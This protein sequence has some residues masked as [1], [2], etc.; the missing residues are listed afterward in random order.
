ML[1][2]IELGGTNI[3]CGV[4]LDGANF[5]ETTQIGTTDPKSAV[6]K[7]S[8]FLSRCETDHRKLQG[9]G[10]ASFGPVDIDVDSQTYGT[11]LETPKSGWSNYSLLKSLRSHFSSPV[12]VTTDVNAALPVKKC[13]GGIDSLVV[14]AEI[15]GDSGL[16][17]ALIIA[18]QAARN[19]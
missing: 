13:I 5:I 7:I 14:K 1:G 12:L 2:A 9:L 17:G 4:S 8:D 10:L 6:L 3:I 15:E 19:G 16:A 18:A 11:I